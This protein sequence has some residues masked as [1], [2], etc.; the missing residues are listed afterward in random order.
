MRCPRAVQALSAAAAIASLAGCSSGS[1]IAPKP[2]TLHGIA[3]VAQ[4]Q[5]ETSVV[6][7][8]DQLTLGLRARPRYRGAS[9]NSCP[10]SGFIVYVSDAGDNTVNIFAGHLAG[11]SPCGII[12]G[13]DDPQG[14]TV[15]DGVLY[16]AN[17]V[18]DPSGNIEAFRRGATTPFK[19]YTDTSCGGEFPSDAAVSNDS[20]VLAANIDSNGC[21]GS[22][23]TWKRVAQTLIG[24]YPNLTGNGT[25]F[26]SIQ[27]DG[28]T[29]YD[30]ALTSSIV[31]LTVG[32]CVA[33]VCTGF[34]NTG[35]TLK[36][37]G[38]I[39]SDNGEHVVVVD[40]FGRG[41][42]TASEYAPPN[43][44]NPV[45]VCK[46][47][48]TEPMT[49]DLDRSQKHLFYADARQGQAF[50]MSHFGGGGGG[51]TIMGSVFTSGRFPIGVAV[52]P[53]ESN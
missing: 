3:H 28:T 23:S 9:F 47:R 32:S 31:G 16:V 41:G 17:T 25:Y 18:G 14:M 15:H 13:F 27:K 19:T 44:E 10:P 34:T 37:P 51:C 11:Q 12:T 20:V 22:I 33:G 6:A 5:R 24:N 49:I 43:F 50:E 38:G 30:G 35:V 4:S 48:G 45:G 7:P 26:L 21:G 36:Y 42:G 1:A 46:L 53:P 2:L 29:Y 39:R 52:D 40:P 8:L